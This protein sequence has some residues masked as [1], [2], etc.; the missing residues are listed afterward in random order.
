N[1]IDASDTA[2]WNGGAGFVPAGREAARFTGDFD[3]RNYS[4]DGLTIARASTDYVGLFG[5]TEGSRLRDLTLSNADVEGRSSVG[6]LAG[7]IGTGSSGHNVSVQGTVE[8]SNIGGGLVGQTHGDISNSH[9][10][11]TVTAGAHSGGL[12]GWVGSQA[13][14]TDSSA[15]MAVSG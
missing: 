7:R 15:S 11:G 6:K 8:A 12:V 3:G 2:G 4:I 5:Y 10:S 14:V 1:D 13:G 9:A